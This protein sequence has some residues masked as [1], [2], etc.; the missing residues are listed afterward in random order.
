MTIIH[1]LIIRVGLSRI[2]ENFRALSIGMDK[3]FTN[4]HRD[5]HSKLVCFELRQCY[6]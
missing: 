4:V 1:Y 6:C 5:G 3:Q 2:K